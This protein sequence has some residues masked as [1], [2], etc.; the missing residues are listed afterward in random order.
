MLQ[1]SWDPEE[2]WSAKYPGQLGTSLVSNHISEVVLHC[3]V[4]ICSYCPILKCGSMEELFLTCG[5]VVS[6]H[7]YHSLYHV[8]LSILKEGLHCT[9][10]DEE[11]LM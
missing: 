3:L 4:L 5:L 9:G 2:C 11:L 7:S 8:M 10:E 1:R 6:W